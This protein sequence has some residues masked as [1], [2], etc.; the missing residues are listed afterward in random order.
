MDPI[1]QT[2]LVTGGFGVIVAW[3]SRPN[4]AQH[5][6]LKRIEGEFR[7]NGGS[8]AKD[9]LT[10][11]KDGVTHLVGR[12]DQHLTESAADKRAAAEEA[13]QMWRA[14]EAVAKAAPPEGD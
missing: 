10:A 11:I 14:I 6:R 8:T 3:I 4:I 1:V 12:F 5:K 2:A 9:D 13:R 7:T